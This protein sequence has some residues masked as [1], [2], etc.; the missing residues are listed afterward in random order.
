MEIIGL[1][2]ARSGSKGLKNKN[3]VDFKGLPL[4]AHTIKSS[5][6]SDLITKTIV[7]TNSNEYADISKK[8]NAEVPFLRPEEISQ[9][10]SRDS[11]VYIHI[12]ES[13]KLSDDDI[14]VHLRPTNPIRKKGL[15]D[16]VIK[17]LIKKDLPAIRSLSKANF[18]PYKMVFMYK[19]EI[20]PVLEIEGKTKGTDIPR[21]LLPIAYELNGNVDAF[22]VKNLKKFDSFF[23]QGTGGFI[24]NSETADI[25]YMKDL[26][27]L[28]ELKKE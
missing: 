8:F 13:L 25:N 27:R 24:E 11:E 20:E 1:I 22:R 15:I 7:S 14:I 21:Q 6:E 3:I 5:N 10:F 23:P 19:G 12:I 17:D 28:N 18:S 2:T 16:S 26:I 4:I 9:D